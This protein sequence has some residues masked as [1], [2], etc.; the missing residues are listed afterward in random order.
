MWL[1]HLLPSWPAPWARA[2]DLET[3]RLIPG[4]VHPVYEREVVRVHG[5]ERLDLVGLFGAV[6]RH[7]DSRTGGTAVSAGTKAAQH[8]TP[9]AARTLPGGG[10]SNAG[11]LA[12]APAE[13]GER[14]CSTAL[15]D[16]NI[17][18]LQYCDIAMPEEGHSY[19]NTTSSGTSIATY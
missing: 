6:F 10:K 14:I 1:V 15:L 3:R 11:S 7:C 5:L 16:C 12:A 9:P 17:A 19:C 8:V 4:G 18:I 13:K 2:R